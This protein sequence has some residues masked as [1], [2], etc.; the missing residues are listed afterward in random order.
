M[1]IDKGCT[2]TTIDSDTAED[3]H[4]HSTDN[5]DVENSDNVVAVEETE[6]N[7]AE[8]TDD[9]SAGETEVDSTEETNDD[10]EPI[11][12]GGKKGKLIA[13]NLSP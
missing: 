1:N 13:R 10:D 8:V 3:V 5:E 9:D 12:V 2:D 11:E 4:D 7:S 6:D